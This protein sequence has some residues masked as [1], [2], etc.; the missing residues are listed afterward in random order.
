[1]TTNQIALE[2]VS[3]KQRVIVGLVCMTLG[4]G[5]VFGIGFAGADTVH[6]AAHDTRHAVGFPCH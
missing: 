2:Q 6:N 1:M 5:M 4:L 3:I